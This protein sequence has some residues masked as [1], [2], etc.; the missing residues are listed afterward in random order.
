M[1]S[2]RTQAPSA[3]L[4]CVQVLQH[5]DAMTSTMLPQDC[6]E[7][8]AAS[9]SSC[10]STSAYATF[11]ASQISPILHAAAESC[12]GAVQSHPLSAH[13]SLCL[14]L[15]QQTGHPKG[16][17]VRLPQP[18]LPLQKQP[19][20]VQPVRV[21]FGHICLPQSGTVHF[22]KRC[23]EIP[24]FLASCM[25]TNS[26][27]VCFGAFSAGAAAALCS[28]AATYLS[29]KMLL[30]PFCNHLSPLPT[31]AASLSAGT[32]RWRTSAGGTGM[33]PT[34]SRSMATWARGGL[35]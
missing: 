3:A 29:E 6:T 12:W 5:P 25:L 31:G 27:V 35:P 16:G 15:L 19:P 1:G 4:A 7:C 8:C 18:G 34:P 22:G 9:S 33:W 17:Q 32:R 30:E 10:A 2:Q 23:E 11:A 24:S 26:C 21:S 13:L 28:T 20:Q 14:L